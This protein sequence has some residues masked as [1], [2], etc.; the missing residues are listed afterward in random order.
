QRLDRASR[1]PAPRTLVR[2]VHGWQPSATTARLGVSGD[3]GQRGFVDRLRR[4]LPDEGKLYLGEDFLRRASRRRVPAP[5]CPGARVVGHALSL[6]TRERARRP[7][8]S[9]IDDG[10]GAMAPGGGGTRGGEARAPPP[11]AATRTPTTQ[12]D[13]LTVVVDERR[14]GMD[15]D[16]EPP[17][18][19]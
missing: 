18:A 4:S 17:I 10:R 19:P 13:R 11:T 1:C 16:S 6:V 5:G 14:D 9:W 2:V 3:A 7:A 12:R 15:L 8:T